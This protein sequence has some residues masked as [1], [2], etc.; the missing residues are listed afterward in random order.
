MNV[1]ELSQQD[2]PVYLEDVSATRSQLQEWLEEKDARQQWWMKAAAILAA[3][4]VVVSLLAWLFPIRGYRP[5]VQTTRLQVYGPGADEPTWAQ[6]IQNFG[7][8]DAKE[9]SLSLGT[10]E[11]STKKIK[12]LSPTHQLMKLGPGLSTTENFPFHRKEFFGFFVTC[13]TYSGQPSRDVQPSFYK[14]ADP[15]SAM[16]N[17]V[18]APT[19]AT[20]VEYETLSAHEHRDGHL[21]YRSQ[22]TVSVNT[23]STPKVEAFYW[24]AITDLG[25]QS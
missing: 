25:G 20:P 15:Q 21:W 16:T 12:L 1:T 23:V 24:A 10:I 17:S 22:G 4:A 8:E 3:L 2:T 9:I 6:S 18:V 5:L 11:W 14:L 19:P 7:Q 13:L